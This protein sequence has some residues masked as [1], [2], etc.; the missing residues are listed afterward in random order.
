MEKRKFPC[1]KHSIA[2]HLRDAG[3]VM[4][5]ASGDTAYPI[6]SCAMGLVSDGT[7]HND[8]SRIAQGKPWLNLKKPSS[9]RHRN[10]SSLC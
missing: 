3:A 2:T 4:V 10:Q 6:T 9:L 8:H 7:S 1:L 5:M